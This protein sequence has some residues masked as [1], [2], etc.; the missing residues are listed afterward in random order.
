MSKRIELDDTGQFA[1]VREVSE[2]TAGDRRAASA[3]YRVRIDPATNELSVPGDY[4]E[5]MHNALAARLITNWSLPH[6]LPKGDPAVLDQLSMAQL[7]ALYGG[8]EEHVTAINAAS[9]PKGKES[10][11]TSGSSI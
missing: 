3:A 4:N 6:P 10:V 5:L 1:E 7:D 2:L 8:I 9:K 11:P